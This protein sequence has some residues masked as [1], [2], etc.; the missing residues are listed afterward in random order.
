MY[1]YEAEEFDMIKADAE[2]DARNPNV[3]QHCGQGGPNPE[4]RRDAFQCGNPGVRQRAIEW[5]AVANSW[6]EQNPLPPDC[7]WGADAVGKPLAFHVS[8]PFRK[9]YEPQETRE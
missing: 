7:W 9:D 1:D 6:A 2:E 8:G 5:R 4:D 3:C